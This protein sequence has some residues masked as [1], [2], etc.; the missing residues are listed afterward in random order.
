MR[1]CIIPTLL[2]VTAVLLSAVQSGFLPLE[3]GIPLS[4]RVEVAAL[5]ARDRARHARMLR[6]VVGGVVDFSVQGS[7]DLSVGSG[8]YF[9]KVKMGTPQREFNVQ[10]DTGSDILWVNCNTCSN[11][12][13][14][15]QLGVRILNLHL[16]LHL[17]LVLVFDLELN[18]L[19][20]LLLVFCGVQIELNFFDTVG[21]TTAAL[22]PCSDP[23]CT[24]GVQGAAAECSPQVNLCSYTFQYGDGSGTS[25]YY[26]LDSMHF[27]MIMGQSP[28]T[29]S[30]ATIVFGCSTYQ[31]GDLTKTDKAVDGIFGFGP[32]ALSVVSQLSS[33]GITPKVFSHCLKGDGDGGGIL[34]LGEI[35]EPS[36]VYSP[37]VPSQPHYNLN[38][39]SI[40][41]NG[42]LLPIN[43]AVFAT[44][45]NRGTIVDCGTT[46]AYLVQE[47]YDPLVTAI[48]TAV[49]QSARITPSKGSQCYLVS[50]SIGDIFPSVSLNFEGGASMVLKP[51]QYLTHNGDLDGA[52]VWCIGFQKV[53]EGISIL[54]GS[55]DVN[56]SVTT[57][58]DEYINAGQLS[59]SSSEIRI[60][61]KLLLLSI[62]ALYMYIML[63]VAAATSSLYVG[64]LHPDVSDGHLFDAF[65]EFK[66]LSSVHVCRDR[67]TRKS[68]CYG[69]VNFLSHQDAIRAIM[70]KNNSYLNG[71]VIR[72]MWSH[73]DPYARKSGR[74]NVF[75]KN[76]AEFIDN[77]GLHD[78]FKK[79]GNIMSSKVVMSEDGKSNK[80][81]GFVQFES[82]ESA[83]DAIEELNGSTVRD[84]QIYVGK[85]VKKSDRILP[86]HDAKFTNLYIKNLDSDI[87]E[88]LLQE[89]FSS[90]GK[91]F[92]L[93]IA[94]EDNG[95]SKGFAFVNYDNPDDARKAMEA[96]NGVKL[97]SSKNLYVARA[98]KKAEREQILHHQFEK[99]RKEQIL[100]YKGSNI[101]V[102]NIDD[103]V[104]DKELRDLFSLCGTI[105]SVKVMRDDKGIS[106]GFGFVCF[107]TP[108]E[109][110][111]AVSTYHGFMF[112]RKP[113]YVA[114]AQRKEDRQTQLKLH[115][116][117]QQAGLNG[118]STAVIPG[119][120]SPYFYT[121][122]ASQMFQSG[123]LYQPVG[124]RSGW[125]ANDFA[126][127]TR[128]FQ[129]SP[130]PIVSNNTRHHRQN[131]GMMNG[132]MSSLGKDHSGLYVPQLQHYYQSVAPSRVDLAAKI[133]G[134]LLE[135]DNGKLSLLLESR[136]LS[137]KVEEALQDFNLEELRS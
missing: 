90:F 132:Y 36:I 6:G 114:I 85:F 11:C 31:S 46:L 110:N 121:D 13:Q 102:K 45:N 23:I 106:K 77:A 28:T 72:V 101:Y 41:V 120:F 78:L 112:H 1:R 3:R 60:L 84:K 71:K 81:H 66:S 22:V 103:G 75:V 48:T 33:R 5:R 42:Q 12:P 50:T 137:V 9:T 26:V 127:P 38:L 35:L 37:L 91:I 16:H 49:S 99:N 74:G 98:Q 76:L 113:L 55:L 56:V 119:G 118:P 92:S 2:A 83:N 133:A 134:M 129:Q 135:M 87:S 136:E 107:S 25:G 69:Y 130:V 96:M 43:Q 117:Q 105:T 80:G 97:G 39:Q 104:N 122:V 123:P 63:T 68:L 65:A 61:S 62:V 54:G 52:S 59:V 44:S 131:R 51:E 86:S 111:V 40:A 8:L 20:L 64:D 116:A 95:L 24:S 70:L 30:S 47:A 10:I 53:Q 109:A 32:G 15:S 124:L 108:K 73:R 67:V 128:S 7:S 79:Y 34:V 82:E 58:K 93:A 57:S 4:R 29:N 18:V 100:K 89:K 125:R 94:R 126:P 14:S 27:E 21:S 19:R 88:A 17:I 115:Y